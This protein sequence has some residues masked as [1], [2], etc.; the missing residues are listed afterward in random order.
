[1]S[2]SGS[3]A[4]QLWALTGA[5]AVIWVAWAPASAQSSPS[6]TGQSD[7]AGLGRAPYSRMRTKLE[8]TIFKV[9]V[10]TA[11]LWFADAD[12]KH[13]ERLADGGRYSKELADS[14]AKIA[15]WSTD[16]LIQLEFLRDVSFDQFLDGIDENL[17]EVP[18][19]GIITDADYQMIS[20]LLPVWYAFLEQRGVLKGDRMDYRIRGDS[21]TTRFLSSSGE[22][23]LNQTDVGP[24]RRLSVLGGYFVRKSDFRE[25]LIKS[26]FE[27]NQARSPN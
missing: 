27:A 16:V 8:K 3:G 24:K 10:L 25:G 15:I 21:L 12:A 13:I 2:R 6:V 9:D 5:L 7:V 18:K 22:L 4:K 11:E 1:M 26:L 17:R 14:I 23:L 19:A 20:G